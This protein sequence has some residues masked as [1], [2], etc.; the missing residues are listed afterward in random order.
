L[1]ACVMLSG[2]GGPRPPKST[3][4]VR[5]LPVVASRV[6][7]FFVFFFSC[8]LRPFSLAWRRPSCHDRAMHTKAR[9]RGKVCR[10]S[11]SCHGRAAYTRVEASLRHVRG[12]RATGA[13]SALQRCHHHPVRP[14]SRHAQHFPTKRGNRSRSCMCLAEYIRINDRPGG[15]GGL[16]TDAVG[17]SSTRC[18]CA[19]ACVRFTPQPAPPRQ[20]RGRPCPWG[21][22]SW[23]P[24]RRP[25]P[26]R[27]PWRPCPHRPS[28]P[29]A[30]RS[31]CT[32]RCG[33]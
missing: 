25:S 27:R 14:T 29:P 23:F 20:R 33:C 15:A 30:R 13:R 28:S 12:I 24:H 5:G 4:V 21:G 1:P 31:G 8:Y 19:R 16:G 10:P 3:L 22:P 18:C 32:R 17:A 26:W 7:L 6:V 9:T 2:S 11:P